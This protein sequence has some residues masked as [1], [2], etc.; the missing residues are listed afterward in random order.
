MA[1]SSTKKKAAE[2]SCDSSECCKKGL[3]FGLATAVFTWAF[4]FLVHGIALKDLYATNAHFFRP[5]AEMQTMWYWCI[6][7][8]VFMGLVFAGGYI[9]WRSK[10]TVGAVGSDD[11]PYKKSGR[12]GLWVG[13][14]LAA[15][16]L[17]AYSW[18][19]LPLDLPL[20]WAGSELV[21]W[22]LAGLVLGALY[23]WKDK[24]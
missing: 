10:I 3:F 24:K 16:Q 12:F 15:P 13:L 9:C 22:V 14:L 11:C 23:R 7:Y 18:M 21:K 4:D 20:A 19:P 8:H 1:K 5:M 2:P 6:G 17:M